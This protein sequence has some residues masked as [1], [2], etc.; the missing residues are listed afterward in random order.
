MENIFSN[1]LVSS[2]T[3]PWPHVSHI[4]GI[5]VPC[6]LLYWSW[7]TYFNF[8]PWL[9]LAPPSWTSLIKDH[10]VVND[11]GH[12]QDTCLFTSLTCC[13]TVFLIKKGTAILAG[14]LGS[15]SHIAARSC[16]SLTLHFSFKWLHPHIIFTLK[17]RNKYWETESF[18]PLLKFPTLAMLTK[19]P[20]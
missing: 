12:C 4:A 19:F 13:R 15:L 9:N 10:Q 1:P 6:H 8:Q 3:C 20:L 5:F 14:I 17:V 7:L 18:F 16:C 2:G 11:P